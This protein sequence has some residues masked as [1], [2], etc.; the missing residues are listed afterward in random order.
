MTALD[1]E[2]ETKKLKKERILSLRQKHSPASSESLLC[3][4]DFGHFPR[5][6]VCF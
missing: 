5:A 1:E 2:P 3:R 6:G 4:S